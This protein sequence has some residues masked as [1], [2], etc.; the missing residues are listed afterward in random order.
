MKVVLSTKS[1]EKI[2]EIEEDLG[3]PRVT[4]HIEAYS[5]LLISLNP[6]QQAFLIENITKIVK[7]EKFLKALSEISKVAKELGLTV[8]TEV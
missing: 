5:K 8:V 6:G 4:I 1:N 3:H 7:E 2:F